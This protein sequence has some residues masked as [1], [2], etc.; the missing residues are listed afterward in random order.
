MDRE[1][2]LVRWRRGSA[3]VRD[4]RGG[5]RVWGGWL[6]AQQ[7]KGC[8]GEPEDHEEASDHDES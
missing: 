4:D 5:M 1:G 2:W 3:E 7:V 6:L 8:C